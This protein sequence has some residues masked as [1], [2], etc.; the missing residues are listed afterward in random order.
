MFKC[1]INEIK[2]KIIPELKDENIKKF[3]IKGINTVE[4][5]KK[6]QKEI[7]KKIKKLSLKMIFTTN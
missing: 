1:H 3:L 4:D 7:I 6:H 2:K 5:L